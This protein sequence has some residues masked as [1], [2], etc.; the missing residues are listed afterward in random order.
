MWCTWLLSYT[1]GKSPGSKD[2][3]P[4][5]STILFPSEDVQLHWQSVKR[6]GAGLMNLGNTC[7]LN[8]TLQCLT[9]TPPLFNY[10]MS[11]RHSTECEFLFHVQLSFGYFQGQLSILLGT[12][13]VLIGSFQK[14]QLK[15]RF[16]AL[17]Q[18]G[19]ILLLRVQIPTS[20]A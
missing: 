2:G 18:M 6:V 10:L 16:W 8:A 19:N 11:R 3:F 20:V 5:P 14:A 12:G 1:V 4:L 17:I 15:F 9:Y 7:F 13:N